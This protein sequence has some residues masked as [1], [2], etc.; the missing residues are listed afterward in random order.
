MTLKLEDIAI[1]MCR[2]IGESPL[3]TKADGT[4][5]TMSD[6]KAKYGNFII[7]P[8]YLD[9]IQVG[10]PYVKITKLEERTDGTS[11]AIFRLKYE[12][13]VPCV[14]ADI[15]WYWRDAPALND[16]GPMGGVVPP[17]YCIGTDAMKADVGVRGVTNDDGCVGPGMGGGAWYNPSHGVIGPHAHWVRGSGIRS[18]IFLG[19]GMLVLPDGQG[20]NHWHINVEATVLRWTGEEP[21]EPEPNEVAQIMLDWVEAVRAYVEVVGCAAGALSGAADEAI[22]KLQE[23]LE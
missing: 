19:I 9:G 12:D 7:W 3:P 13:G 17:E 11:S 5:W 22:Q 16:A 15:V 20:T 4:P 2:N 6:M 10:D 14:G 21:E 8:A 18:D 1:W 23:V